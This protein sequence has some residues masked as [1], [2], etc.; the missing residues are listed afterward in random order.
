MATYTFFPCQSDGPAL[1]FETLELDGDGYALAEAG[2]LLAKHA[3]AAFITV[4]CGDRMVCSV[5]RDQAPAVEM[6]RALRWPSAGEMIL[7]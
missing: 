6:Q 2:D 7:H 4:W 3:T 1:C 5:P